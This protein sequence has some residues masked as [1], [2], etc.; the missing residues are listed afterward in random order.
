[1]LS[2][3]TVGSSTISLLAREQTL[4]AES[5]RSV[6]QPMPDRNAFTSHL[7]LR[8]QFITSLRSCPT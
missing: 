3:D 5:T 7:E 4:G 2:K 6:H 1:L 8:S